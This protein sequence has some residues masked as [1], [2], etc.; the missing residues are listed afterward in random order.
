MFRKLEA[1]A[2]R[3]IDG[4]KL[5]AQRKLARLK[6]KFDFS[7]PEQKEIPDLF[8]G[9]FKRS[10]RAKGICSFAR[11]EFD[12]ANAV[13]WAIENA[14]GVRCLYRDCEL[15]AEAA[16]GTLKRLREIAN[17][18]SENFRTLTGKF[19]ALN[20]VSMED[21]GVF[22]L[23]LYDGMMNEKR[24][25]RQSLPSRPPAREKWASKKN[26]RPG[27]GNA[28]TS[29][30]GSSQSW[31]PYSVFGTLARD[32]RGV[33]WF[34]SATPGRASHNLAAAPGCSARYRSRRGSGRRVAVRDRGWP[35]ILSEQ[36]GSQ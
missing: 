7:A 11:A 1:L 5:A 34:D 28:C 30:Y 33:G 36:F 2:E 4:E 9:T 14:T 26:Q 24:E 17:H 19:N 29:L 18:I 31:R 21:R 10:S 32:Q 12:I 22:L 23:G 13:K 15:L 3:G 35:E 16:P 20:G 6:L 25:A 8:Q 27:L